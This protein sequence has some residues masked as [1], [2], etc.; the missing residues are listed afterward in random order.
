MF[1]WM[2]IPN[3]S[4]THID[5]LITSNEKNEKSDGGTK[6]VKFNYVSNEL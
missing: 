3:V 5:D 2:R 4:E 6:F 1:S